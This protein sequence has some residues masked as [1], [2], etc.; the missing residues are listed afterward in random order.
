MNSEST[1]PPVSILASTVIRNIGQLVTIAQQPLPNANG[2][3]QVISNA[4][5]AVHNGL[6]VWL[7]HDNDAEP[8]FQSD[9]NE[10]SQ[11]ITIIDALG[12]VIT[13]GLV[14][15]HT[16]V[17]FAN[18][19]IAEAHHRAFNT[20]QKNTRNAQEILAQQQRGI[21]AVTDATRATSNEIL[22][23]QTRERLEIMRAHGTT[24][25]EIKSGYGLDKITEEALLGTI[26]SLI[27]REETALDRKTLMRIVPTFL[28]AH[29]LPREYQDRRTEYVDL[30]TNN[31]LPSFVG[32]ARF[33]DVVCGQDAF[34]IEECRRIL[35]R[36]R[37]LGYQLKLSTDQYNAS[38]GMHLAA[39]L[40]T[41]SIDY[42][43]NTSDNDLDTLSVAGV[44]VVLLPGNAY[45]SQGIYPDA[46]RLLDHGL[47]VAL[48]TNCNP[49]T[50]Y[51]E[52]LQMMLGLAIAHMG[53]TLEEALTAITLNGARAL[54][55]QDE[56]GS[57]EVGKRCELTIWSVDDYQEI[58]YHFGVN[59]VRSI[60]VQ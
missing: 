47:H 14:D 9:P 54:G 13:P 38:D 28:A 49:V 50:S 44:V 17:I 10:Q 58:G 35:V 18:T 56:I 25:V 37:E 40:A 42:L 3:L 1:K 36:A 32:L 46:R 59:L 6:I 30:V 33:C 27:A 34:T 2:A 8:L 20:N 22:L 24:T 31:M 12:A 26:L 52:N 48:A 5:I 43:D 60:L 19:N 23:E 53:M 55:L 39:E 41:I 29:T 21:L 45:T 4:A 11:D 7:G 16:H 15:A 51:S 57:I